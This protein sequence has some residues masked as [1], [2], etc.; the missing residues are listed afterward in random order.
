MHTVTLWLL[1]SLGQVS[2]AGSPHQVVERFAT[3]QECLR[4]AAIL[5]SGSQRTAVQCVEATIAITK[6]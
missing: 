2:Y 6:G 4:V 1:I 3:Q 5:R